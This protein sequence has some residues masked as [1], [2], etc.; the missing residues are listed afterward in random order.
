MK[1]EFSN[2]K[3]KN[4][5]A[6]LISMKKRQLRK[7]LDSV[8]A[9]PLGENLEESIIDWIVFRRSKGLQVLLKLVMKWHQEMAPRESRAESV[10]FK[11]SREW[12]A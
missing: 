10:E 7:R 11:A 6:S 3:N 12:L 2:G 8:G 9:K 1:R 4:K 5:I